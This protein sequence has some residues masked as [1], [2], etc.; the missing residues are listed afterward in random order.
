MRNLEFS[1]G[2]Y[3]H[4]YN[5]GIEKRI[6]FLEEND[7]KRFMILLYLCNSETSV[8]LYRSKVWR[9][10]N[11]YS[12]ERKNPI[13]S[14]GAYCLMPNHFHILIKEI[15]EGGISKFMQKLTT[16]YTMYFNIK[17]N[18][19]GSLFENTFK[20]KHAN[21]DRYLK[22]LFTY[23]HL[24]PIKIIDPMWKENKIR[25]L[26]N[27][28]IFLDGYSYSSFSE[29]SE[30]QRIESSILDKASFPNYFLNKIDL[31]N[32]LIDFINYDDEV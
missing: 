7:Y 13:I 21:S 31:D 16:A 28:K 29:Y 14:I 26:N 27:Y 12:I 32:T 19:T 10:V 15:S 8:G 17:Y 22:Y 1:V 3:Y 30:Q 2:E 9:T 24:N 23:I 25:N 20:A 4:I 5:R 6:I 18:R 11:M